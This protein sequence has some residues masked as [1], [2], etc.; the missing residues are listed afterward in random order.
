MSESDML[1]DSAG[2]YRWRFYAGYPDDQ[3]IVPHTYYLPRGLPV[4][5]AFTGAV[6]RADA[7]PASVI[8]FS[9][10]SLAASVVRDEDGD[11]V[12]DTQIDGSPYV[13][14]VTLQDFNLRPEE[15]PHYVQ[16]GHFGR[17]CKS[18]KLRSSSGYWRYYFPRLS[19]VDLP[20]GKLVPGR[21]Y[22]LRETQQPYVP[23]PRV[24]G[25]SSPRVPDQVIGIA[26]DSE[27]LRLD[28]D[29]AMRS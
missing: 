12:I 28:A 21:E 17:F 15:L 23:W 4:C 27:T 1:R 2:C 11:V 24:S 29:Y 3:S 9:V 19:E 8:G 6:V 18:M 10:G 13:A 7:I 5:S 14:N 26:L 16:N 25:D 20:G 22:T